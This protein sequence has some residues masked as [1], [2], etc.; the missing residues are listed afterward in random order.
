[1]SGAVEDDPYEVEKCGKW[2]DACNL[3]KVRMLYH[4]D[5][6]FIS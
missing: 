2:I 6:Y 3:N 4:C 1:M 5:E